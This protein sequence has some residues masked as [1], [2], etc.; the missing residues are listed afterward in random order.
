MRQVKYFNDLEIA[1]G[2]DHVL[3][4]F[5]TVAKGDSIL[6]EKEQFTPFKQERFVNFEADIK[7]TVS[8]LVPNPQEVFDEIAATEFPEVIIGKTSKVKLELRTYQ[9]LFSFFHHNPRFTLTTVFDN[10]VISY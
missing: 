1:F 6:A 10:L 7:S 2:I 5:V 8:G 4:F 9:E 3:G